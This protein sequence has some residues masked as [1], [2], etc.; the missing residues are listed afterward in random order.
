RLPLKL[1]NGSHTPSYD[2]CE[3]APEAFFIMISVLLDTFHGGLD[4]FERRLGELE[5]TM[6]HRNRT[7]L[8]DVIFDRRYD[9]L[10]WSHL[11]IPI[12]EVHGAAKEAFAEELIET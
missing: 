3:H 12:R 5:R 11:F 1:Q 8:L 9:L 10:H 6:R 7:D 4:G 2:E